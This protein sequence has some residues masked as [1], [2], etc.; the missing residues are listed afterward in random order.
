MIRSDTRQR[1]LA[2]LLAIVTLTS[3]ITAGVVFAAGP[4]AAHD[5]H[6]AG[7]GTDGSNE[8][9]TDSD[10]FRKETVLSGLQRPTETVFLPDGRMLVIQQGGEILID[11]PDTNGGAE[12]YLDLKNVDSIE[13]QR[14]RG[15]LGIALAPDFQQSGEF[16]LYYTRL[17]NPNAEEKVDTDPRNVLAK[18]EHVENGGGT[19][20][21]GEPAGESIEDAILWRNEIRAGNSIVCCHFGGG[22]D[23]GPD[24]KIY[25]TTGDEFQGWRAQDLSVPDGKVI[26][27]NQDGSIPQDNPYANDGDPETLG[28]IWAS[29]LRNPYRAKFAPNGNFYIGE[30]GGNKEPESQE[31][32]NIGQKGA[33]YGWPD[34]EG[35]C[36]DPSYTDPLYTYSHGESGFRPGAAVTVGPVYTGDAYP[37]EYDNVLFYS[38]YND[39]WIK[40]LTLNDDGTEVGA[41]YNFARQAGAIVSMTTGPDGALYGTNYIG[42]TGEGSIIRYVYEGT[43]A[44]TVPSI[45]STSVTPQSG[46]APLDV[47]FEASA[48]DPDGDDLTYTW[49]FGDG[50]SAEGASVTHTYENAGSYDAYVEV[51]DGNATVE[52]DTTTVSAGG[53]PNVEITSPADGSTFRAGESIDVTANVTDPEDGELSG[54]AIEWSV[55]LAHNAHIHPDSTPT[56]ES[57]TFDVPTTGHPT[58]GD[59]GYTISVTATDSDGLQTT[60]SVEIRPEEVD[61]TLR[62]EPDG[63]PVDVEGSPES[64]DGGYTFDTVIGYE[65]SLS[66]PQSVCRQGT[67]YEFANWSDGDT[68]RTRTY[69]VP[70]A[71]ATLTARYEAAGSCEGLPQSGL[72]G[73]YEAD[74]GVTTN[75]SA[76][77]GWTDASGNGNDLDAAGAPQFVAGGADGAAAVAFDGEDD[78][79]RRTGLTGFPAGGENRTM[80]L[81]ANYTDNGG[82]F[83]GAAYGAAASNRA[84]GLVVDDEGMLTVQGFGG[85]NDFPAD[86]RGLGAGW[87][88][89]S[90]V[91]EDGQFTQYA[92]GQQLNSG[93]HQFQTNPKRF[94]V[95]GEITPPPYTEMQV[96]AV[97]V[98]DRALSE[99]ERRQVQN[100]LAAKYVGTDGAN[101]PPRLDDISVT[102]TGG[103]KVVDVTSRATDDG[104]VDASSVRVVEGPTNGT[105][106][107]PGNGSVT[108]TTT[109]AN[110]TGDAFTV[111]IS[112]ANGSESA[113]A[114]VD[115]TYQISEAN[116]PPTANDDAATVTAGESVEI[117]VTANDGDAD[118]AVD[119]ASVTVVDGPAAG[120]VTTNGDGTVTYTHT[121]DGAT[122]DS[123]TYEVADGDGAVSN[124]ATVEVTVEAAAP[125]DDGTPETRDDYAS[126]DPGGE[127]TVD[128]LAN[129]SANVDAETLRIDGDGEFGTATVTNGELVY[130]HDGGATGDDLIEY[131]VADESGNRSAPTFVFV[132]V[133]EST[134]PVPDDGGSDGSDDSSGDGDNENDS[135]NDGGNGNDGDDSNGGGSNPPANPGGGGG[136][137]DDDDDDRPSRQSSPSGSSGSSGSVPSADEEAAFRV[138][139]LTL[140]A[141]NVG[142]GERV[143][144]SADVGNVGDANGTTTVEL[145]VGNGTV[146]SRNVTLDAGANATLAFSHAFDAAGTYELRIGNRSAGTVT[147][148]D[149]NRTNGSAGGDDAGTVTAGSGDDETTDGD[150][151]GVTDGGETGDSATTADGGSDAAAGADTPPEASDDESQLTS[152]TGTGT[153]TGTPG[154]GVVVAVFSMLLAAT[155]ARRRH[156]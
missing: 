147:V 57:F 53:A 45:D 102:Y 155:L 112:D 145:A 33:N 127:V 79:L 140:S 108:Y 122:T 69:T 105:V 28:E 11:D 99:T 133:N 117:P 154:F 153:S 38:D 7:G 82:G 40:Y 116:A 10:A 61:V 88:T 17:A 78:V 64:T 41:S 37:D 132:D 106:T 72:V 1:A 94:V 98:Y 51:T 5:D 15:L 149:A 65:H 151:S 63:V 93:T 56:G 118:G 70:D 110:A 100:Y 29:G 137:D 130:R 74:A 81:V 128:V 90:V 46:A 126:V 59:V 18:F 135:S 55:R 13:S 92:N 120:E 136:G 114:T 80:F 77:T 71:D 43:D 87:L 150:E 97:L 24:G 109:N 123:F 139:N 50:T 16:Y 58:T 26:R 111:A 25:I 103:Q 30:V 49:Y 134:A 144:A 141:T 124:V 113:P 8:W 86:R 35:M 32:I 44:D 12:T 52:S 152:E 146:A 66:A 85:G 143:N 68:D 156:D 129:D 42:Q 67:T 75:G 19:A 3:S 27:L 101:E 21:R 31:D 125:A 36:E 96:S 121:G 142:V 9:A 73:H 22:L 54:D 62:T 148:V 2:V 104:D 39:G 95:G 76:V 20:S 14:E 60:E 107:N 91:Y 83:G 131:T 48:S 115:L 4:A 34:C 84:F 6:T 119:D 138:S 89:Q 47:T 23:V